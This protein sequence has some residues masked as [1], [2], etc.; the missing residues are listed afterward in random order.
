MTALMASRPIYGT[1]PQHRYVTLDL[2][3]AL[4][5][6]NSVNAECDAVSYRPVPYQ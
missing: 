1:G 5:Y 4:S 6:P 2:A 3:L